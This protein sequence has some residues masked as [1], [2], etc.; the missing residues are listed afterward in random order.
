[1]IIAINIKII[2]KDENDTSD[3]FMYEVATRIVQAHPQ[4]TFIIISAKPIANFVTAVNVI[5]VVIWPQG[6]HPT[7]WLV[8]YNLKIK[9]V[10]KKYK[11]NIFISY[12][13][14]S[15]SLK[16]PQY[17][18]VADL[19]FIYHPE[20]YRRTELFFY[21]KYLVKSLKKA[22]LILTVS[23]FCKADI[24]KRFKINDNNVQVV[25]KGSDT[26]FTEINNEDHEK[27]KTKLTDGNHYF[28]Y[29]GEISF[30]K[31]ILNLLKAF[32]AFKKRQ[33]SNM[34]LVIAGKPGFKYKD[35]IESLRLFK[36]KDEV[37]IISDT[38]G[39]EIKKIIA[40]AYAF[41]YL[42]MYEAFPTSVMQAMSYGAPVVTS[43]AA[44][45]P[46][47]CAGAALYADPANFK[48]MAIQMMQLYKNE[49][50]RNDLIKKGKAQAAKYNWDIT[51]DLVWKNIQELY[52][53]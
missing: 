30:H 38:T 16:V 21:K 25:Y 19:N 27:I 26:S 49:T 11:A 18:I 9:S 34:Q 4:H 20:I 41:V 14:G 29:A 33:K 2:G 46:E 5:N 50:I 51:A 7:Q 6:R 15:L 47:I 40:A 45:M 53:F 1:M 44:S 3:N 17:I 48:E 39:E 42:S 24:I 22:S 23:E 43:S 8:W 32:S 31:N 52:N 28:L 37:K 12:G 10:I 36:F 13:V 35:I